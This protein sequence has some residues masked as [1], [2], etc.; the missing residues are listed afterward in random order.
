MTGFADK[1]APWS[2]EEWVKAFLTG[3]GVPVNPTNIATVT[4]WG[5]AESGGWNPNAAGGKNNPLNIVAVS[6]DGHSGV[7]GSQGNIADF[8]DPSTGAKATIA[9]FSPKGGA[10]QKIVDAL[11]ASNQSATNAA[12]NAFYSSW[13]SSYTPGSTAGGETTG[14]GDSGTTGT[15]GTTATETAASG[16]CPEG[17]LI[18]FP[19]P[20]P[21]ISRCEGR[22]LLGGACLIAGVGILLVGLAL[23]ASG[24][25]TGQAITGA[26]GAAFG[27]AGKAAVL[28]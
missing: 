24:T 13:G 25:K 5:N 17:N 8:P 7:G 12:I 1:V 19:G 18:T 10:K 11:K 28:A 26:A 23:I 14:G 27:T 22:A 20:I 15:G 21:N 6:G 4:A 16:G 2:T 3:L 9:F